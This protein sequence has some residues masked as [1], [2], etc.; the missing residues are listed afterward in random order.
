M[1]TANRERQRKWKQKQVS[2]GMRAVTVMLSVGIKELID[3]KR[4]ETGTTIAHIIE[5]AVVN[6]LA[7]PENASP[8]L[9]KSESNQVHRELSTAKIQQ[10]RDDL[11]TIVH[12][13]E[14]MA[15]LKSS[16]TGNKKSVTNDVCAPSKTDDPATKEIYRL[17]RLLNNMEISPDEI[18]LTLNKRKFK[19][20]SGSLEWKVGDV[21]E[22]LKDIHQKYGYLNPLFSLSD[23]P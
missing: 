5:T 3:N 14:Q 11:K 9:F 17:V 16:V 1:K 23:T 13:F 21:H 19:P 6:L 15:G 18:A 2:N 10:I 4:K 7:S 12:R 22:V 20:L 8:N